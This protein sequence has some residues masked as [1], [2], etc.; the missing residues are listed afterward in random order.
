MKDQ[1]FHGI[2]CDGEAMLLMINFSSAAAEAKSLLNLNDGATQALSR[3]LS[4]AVLLA[5][6]NKSE[7]E[8][9]TCIL[10]GGGPIGKMLVTAENNGDVKGYVEHPDAIA[11]TSEF[12]LPALIG[13]SGQLTVIRDNPL[14]EP[15]VGVTNLVFGDITRDVAA[16]LVSSE[17]QPAAM[18]LDC[19]IDEKIICGGIMI[20]PYPG[21][22]K[23]AIDEIDKKMTSINDLISRLQTH[24]SL[25]E[26]AYDMFWDIGIKPLETTDTRYFCSCT[27]QRF[28]QGLISLGKNELLSL[29]YDD[30][31]TEIC[32]NFCNKKYVFTREEIKELV[33]ELL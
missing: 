22:S 14:G 27:R 21:A 11:L 17:Q 1:I 30:K 23:K 15:Y 24:D 7:S 3:L 16:Y 9:L 32:C 10:Q 25:E 20:I 28:E 29:A 33:G 13:K 12:S 18:A 8:K 4:A 5:Q 19:R 6:R 26:M 31:D 2:I